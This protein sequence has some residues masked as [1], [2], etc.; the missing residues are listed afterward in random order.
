MRMVFWP[1]VIGWTLLG[2]WL[3]SLFIRISI[4]KDKN[5]IHA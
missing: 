5:I 1:A 4:Q 3:S 2:T